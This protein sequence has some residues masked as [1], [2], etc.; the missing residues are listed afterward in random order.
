MKYVEWFI[1]ICLNVYILPLFKE[2]AYSDFFKKMNIEKLLSDMD[3]WKI[4][5]ESSNFTQF[6]NVIPKDSLVIANNGLGDNLYVSLNDSI[7][8]ILDNKIYV[9]WHEGNWTEIIS[10]KIEY[11]TEKF[12][13]KKPSKYKKIYYYDRKTNVKLGDIVIAKCFFTK[14]KGKINYLPGVSNKNPEYEYSGIMEAAIK[15]DNG[16]TTATIVEP[17]NFF[18]QKH[19]IFISRAKE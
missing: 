6:T 17:K 16:T 1:L 14:K 2:K 11:L 15:F 18:L 7:D 12:I 5:I 19:I 9:F 8:N 3:T 13:C 10:Q 4:C